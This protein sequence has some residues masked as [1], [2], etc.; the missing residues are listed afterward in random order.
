MQQRADITVYDSERRL[1]LIVDTRRK[2]HPSTEWVAQMRQNLLDYKVVPPSPFFLLAL[3]E[4]FYLWKGNAPERH[5]APPD[6]VIDAGAAL[7]PYTSGIQLPLT[8]LSSFS[9]QILV[10]SW[11]EDLIGARIDAESAAEGVRGLFDSGLY[12]AIEGGAIEAAI[13]A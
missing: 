11:L 10:T 13:A 2:L 6:Y 3:P 7:A 12:D 9:L 5:N 4:A 1:Q 8:E